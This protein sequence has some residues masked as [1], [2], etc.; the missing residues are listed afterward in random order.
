MLWKE[1]LRGGRCRF[2]RIKVREDYV[3]C[4]NT[5]GITIT[6][7]GT[8]VAREVLP[9]IEPA[10]PPC[11]RPYSLYCVRPDRLP[12]K[13]PVSGSVQ[14]C[15]AVPNHVE[16]RRLLRSLAVGLGRL[17]D[18]EFPTCQGPGLLPTL[19]QLT[20]LRC[21]SFCRGDLDDPRRDKRIRPK[22]EEELQSE[23]VWP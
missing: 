8:G 15:G 20:R 16:D 18:L 13:S 11:G 4:W 12:S 21:L 2:V 1:E 14:S 23:P 10:N 6:E 9:L 5:R 17:P 19:H 22:K 7:L 3:R